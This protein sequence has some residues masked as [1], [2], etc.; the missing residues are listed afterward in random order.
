[1][2][3]NHLI[4]LKTKFNCCILRVDLATKWYQETDY[5]CK[6]LTAKLCL[7]IIIRFSTVGPRRRRRWPTS[8][9]FNSSKA[10]RCGRYLLNCCH[11]SRRK[12]RGRPPK[13]FMSILSVLKLCT[14]NSRRTSITWQWRTSTSSNWGTSFLS[15]CGRRR[16]SR[17]IISSFLKSLACVLR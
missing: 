17:V 6:S 11:T 16:A 9:L 3:R 7:L 8:T 13:I 5:S 1:M 14:R 4:K 12:T 10:N 2:S 15:W